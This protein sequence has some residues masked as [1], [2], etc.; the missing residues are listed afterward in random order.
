MAIILQFVD[1]KRFVT[2]WFFDIV[3]VPDTT[4]QTLKDEI[5]K[6]LGKYNLLVENMC[7]QGYDGASNMRSTWNGLQVLFQFFKNVRMYI[8]YIGLL[9]VYNLL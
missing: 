4:F 6:M 3:N 5:C 9:I 7:G 2:E 8:M 1:C